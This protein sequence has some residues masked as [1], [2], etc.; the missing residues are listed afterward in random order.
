MPLRAA[1]GSDEGRN[2]ARRRR[3]GAI[4]GPRRLHGPGGAAAGAGAVL[5]GDRH[6]PRAAGGAVLSRRG[7]REVS[8]AGPGAKGAIPTHIGRPLSLVRLVRILSVAP[9][10]R[11]SSERRRRRPRIQRRRTGS[12]RRPTPASRLAAACAS[13]KTPRPLL[14]TPRRRR[15]RRGRGRPAKPVPTTC[16]GR[17]PARAC[18]I[19]R[20]G[21]CDPTARRRGRRGRGQPAPSE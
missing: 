8:A 14:R 17:G 1:A 13:S 10:G 12:P 15:G 19:P 18:S 9:G 4:P 20:R 6:G 3:G 21:P 5:C 2:C 16:R 11:G 7:T